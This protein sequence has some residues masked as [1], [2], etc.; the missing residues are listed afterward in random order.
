MKVKRPKLTQYQRDFLYCKERFSVVEAGTKTGKTF[1]HIYW[2]YEQAL[3]YEDKIKI[4]E[5]KEGMNFWWVAPVYSQAEIAFY[6][7]WRRLAKSGSYKKNESKLIIKTPAGAEIFFKSADKPDNLYGEDVYAAVFDEFTRAK[8]EAWFALRS[9]LTATEAKCKFIGNYKGS[10]NWGHQLGLKHQ[11]DDEYAYF[12]VTALDAVAAGI[13]SQKEIDQARKDLPTFLF[14]ALYLAEGDVDKARLVS[15]ANIKNLLTNDFV[16]HG[17]RY[18]SAD[19]AFEGADLFVIFIWSGLR[20]IGFKV[21]EKND[22]KEIEETIKAM[23]HEWKVPRSNIVYDADGVGIFLK[24]YLSDAVSFKNGAPPVPIEGQKVDY[25]NLKSQCEFKLA[26][27]I[28]AC[29]MYFD[30]DISE[31]WLSI[32]EELE[33]LK[34]RSLGTDGKLETLRR[35]DTIKLIGHSADFL[36]AL[37]MRMFFLLAS[38]VKIKQAK[39]LTNNTHKKLV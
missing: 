18:L 13:L 28:T 21:I 38:S 35:D 7:L 25:K 8:Q 34:N 33:S 11:T 30:C 16:A 31:H 10:S 22:G 5:I 3:G 14:K 9:T 2:L 37:M 36:K 32:M 15:D 26:E 12:K 17:D 23:A 1:S 24:G 27:V 4:R 19:I 6:R 39:I 29:L 20:V